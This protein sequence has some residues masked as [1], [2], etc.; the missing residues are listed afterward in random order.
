VFLNGAEV[1]P[2]RRQ[3]IAAD[4]GLSETVFVDDAE[5]GEI[6]TCFA[7]RPARWLSGAMASWST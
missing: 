1:P 4:L 3:A 5:R 2:D 7:R 6:R